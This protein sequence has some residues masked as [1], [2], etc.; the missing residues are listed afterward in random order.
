MMQL[1]CNNTVLDLYENTKIQFT[2]DNPLFAFDDV[3]CERTTQ[4]KLPSTP[5][6]DRVLSL[7]RVPAYE[8]AGMRSRFA[9]ELQMSGVI[10]RGYL[11]VSAF[12]GKDY[13]AIL[14]T[15]EFANLQKIKDAGKIQD[16]IVPVI[17]TPWANPA[18]AWDNRTETWKCLKYL[19]QKDPAP[20]PFPSVRLSYIVQQCATA[21]GVPISLPA[22]ADYLRIIPNG[23]KGYDKASVVI[24][25]P[26]VP[27]STIV[28]ELLSYHGLFEPCTIPLKRAV[29]ET[30]Y[31]SDEQGWE[32]RVNYT[33]FETIGTIQ[34]LRA[35][36]DV[37]IY[38]NAA[39]AG[40][41]MFND[42]GLG[43]P[44][45]PTEHGS[46]SMEMN[47]QSP[48]YSQYVANIDSRATLQKWGVLIPTPDDD[49]PDDAYIRIAAGT[50]F[51]LIDTNDIKAGFTYDEIQNMPSGSTVYAFEYEHDGNAY[52][53]AGQPAYSIDMNILLDKPEQGEDVM[54]YPNLPDCTLIELLK[55]IAYVTGKILTYDD[56]NGVHFI[57]LNLNATPLDVSDK[58]IAFKE[59]KR[60]FNG[61]GQKNVVEFSSDETIL[62]VERITLAYGID[63]DNLTETKELARIYASEGSAVGDSI[64]MR[65]GYEDIKKET[66]CTCQSGYKYLC[67]VGLPVNSSLQRLS[68]VSTQVKTNLRMT[69]LEYE[70]IKNDTLLY[71]NGLVYVWTSRNGSDDVAQF[72]LA[73]V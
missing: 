72:T 47:A 55:M 26:H 67:R 46:A 35:R 37:T 22:Q 16:I 43:D 30:Y 19:Q 33:G 42:Y 9:A 24:S 45:H 60:E 36:T 56:V 8:G 20:I 28:N 73:K 12:D 18:D 71:I 40:F 70:Q 7:A 44:A 13:N 21:L 68:N 59:I 54:L 48:Y 38:Y 5:V 34:G 2:H 50:E 6:N 3:K 62:N 4:F 64:Y 15:G 51:A 65:N 32:Q 41:A 29:G 63:N 39:A 23:V 53:N 17:S 14:V 1:L 31:Y 69:A 11:Y 27:A 10:K 66:V 25:K 61:W 49:E 58:V 57:D 52:T